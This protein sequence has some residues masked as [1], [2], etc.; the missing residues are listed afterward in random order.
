MAN[1]SLNIGLWSS[2]FFDTCK[3]LYN[4]NCALEDYHPKIWLDI[5]MWIGLVTLRIGDPLE[6]LYS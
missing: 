4:S 2:A 5:V 6:G 3:A 1:L